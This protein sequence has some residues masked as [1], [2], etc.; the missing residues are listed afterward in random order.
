[1]IEIMEKLETLGATAILET[2]IA[3]CRL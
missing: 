1:V 2:A 3:N